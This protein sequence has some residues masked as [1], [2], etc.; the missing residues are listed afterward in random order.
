[1]DEQETLIECN[2]QRK[3]SPSQI[4]NEV[5][6]LEKIER[7]RAKIRKQ[8]TQLAGKNVGG[9]AI[10]VAANLPE[11]KEKG[12]TR[13]I[14]ANKVGVPQKKLETILEIGKLAETG[15]TRE[16]REAEKKA[17]NARV[18]VAK[19]IEAEKEKEKEKVIIE[20]EEE[21][22]DCYD[23]E[24]DSDYDVEED[25]RA[26]T[27]QQ[28]ST[29]AVPSVKTEVKQQELVTAPTPENLSIQHVA[30]QVMRSLDEN[31]IPVSAA[32]EVAKAI[33]ENPEVAKEIENIQL[34]APNVPLKEVVSVA[35]ENAGKSKFNS[36]ND[37][38]EWAKWTWNPVTGCKY[39]CPYCYAKDIA[40][41]FN[42]NGFEPTFHESRLNAPENTVMPKEATTDVGFK[43]VFVCSMADLFGDWVPDEWIK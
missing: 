43:N 25:D 9:N 31:K 29:P 8:S 10:S 12:D 24:E 4:Y 7:E 20:Q 23:E 1:M 36:T 2:R 30:K 19:K 33:N 34:A 13:E 32:R 39:G 16:V 17:E 27:R 18:A 11:P 22:E 28:P 26:V 5:K 15:K 3:K 35:K 14:L 41:R 6:L 21:E 37:N 42:P 38:I 40:N